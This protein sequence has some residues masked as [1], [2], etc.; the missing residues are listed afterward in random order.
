MSAITF[1]IIAIIF[2]TT[3]TTLQVAVYHGK[4]PQRHKLALII[5]LLAVLSHALGLWPQIVSSAGINFSVIGGQTLICLILSLLITLFALAKPVHNSKL[6]IFPA[7]ILSI[8][9]LLNSDRHLRVVSPTET[10]LLVHAALSVVAYAIFLLAAVQAGLLYAQN[11]QLKHHL[12]GRL[13]KALPPL[14]TTEAILFE[15][16]WAGITLLTLSILT[17]AIFVDDLFA[18][19]L[20]HKTVF[21]ILSWLLFCGLL[22]AR[23]FWGWRGLV[24]A[25]ITIVGFVFLMLGYL[26]SNIVIEYILTDRT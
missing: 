16:I 2:Y 21:S 23:R 4:I 20:A 18:Q 12:T 11:K 14:Q 22:M 10:G 24:A 6:V 3:A 8:I 1:S 19:R 17:G 9:L 15:M 5:A 7:A 13:I 25:K 26:G